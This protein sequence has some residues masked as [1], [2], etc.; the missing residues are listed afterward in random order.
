M[1]F[2]FWSL[3]AAK[4]RGSIFRLHYPEFQRR[5]LPA[6]TCRELRRWRLKGEK[7]HESKMPIKAAEPQ[8]SELNRTEQVWPGLTWPRTGPSA[9]GSTW[10]PP[11]VSQLFSEAGSEAADM[12]SSQTSLQNPQNRT[13][14]GTVDWSR[15]WFWFCRFHCE[16]E[17]SDQIC[18]AGRKRQ[19]DTSWT[20]IKTTK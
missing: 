16:G 4:L 18:A 7:R 14:T 20:S 9:P 15:F 12:V 11:K 8:W 5:S 1:Q 13:G 2:S 17:G 10:D 6:H 3:G 19:T